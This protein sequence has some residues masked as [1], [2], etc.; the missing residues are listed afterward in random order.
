MDLDLYINEL[1]EKGYTMIPNVINENEI[2]DYIFEFNKWMDS[3]EN[4]DELHS[5]IH[6]NGIFKYFNVGHQRFA[7]LL[8]T[9]NKIQNI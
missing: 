2:M 5:M 4:S 7:W 9:N 3:F 1:F 6:R 8:R